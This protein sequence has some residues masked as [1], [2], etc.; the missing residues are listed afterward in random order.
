MREKWDRIVDNVSRWYIWSIKK[1]FSLLLAPFFFVLLSF[2]VFRSC[3]CLMTHWLPDARASDNDSEANHLCGQC[4]SLHAKIMKKKL[5]HRR[6]ATNGNCIC[7]ACLGDALIR[8]TFSTVIAFH[9]NRHC[10]CDAHK[11]LY[12]CMVSMSFFWTGCINRNTEQSFS[13]TKIKWKKNHFTHQ[14]K[15]LMLKW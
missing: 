8:L 9:S 1:F 10:M 13:E 12:I 6:M 15:I 11:S 2:S 4:L 7:F 5:F 3:N 14:Q